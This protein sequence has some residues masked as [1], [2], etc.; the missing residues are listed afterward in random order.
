MT[1]REE[2]EKRRSGLSAAKQVLLEKRKQRLASMAEQ[3]DRIPRRPPHA[4]VPASFAQQ[5]FWFIHQLKPDNTAYNEIKTFHVDQPLDERVVRRA[6]LELMQRHE[7]LRST[8]A[9]ADGQLQQ[10][11]HPYEEAI[12][13]LS[14]Q[15][16]DIGQTP[17]E[18]REQEA[19]RQLHSAVRRP[20]DLAKDF[21]W[22]NLVI[23]MGEETIVVSVVHH[24]LCDGWGLDIFQRELETLYLAFLS[25]QPSPLPEL[26]VQYADF[27]FW[28][29]Q[30]AR[31]D[32]WDQQLAY[33][34]NTLAQASQQPLLYGDHPRQLMQDAPRASVSLTVPA[35]VT[36]KLRELSY[37]EGVTLFMVLLATFQ[38]LLFQYS[39]QDDIVVGTPVTRRSRPELEPLIGCFLNMLILRTDVAGDPTFQA[40]LQR[41]RATALG[42]YTNQDIPFETLVADLAPERHRNR[43]PFFQVMLDFQNYQQ[44][45]AEPGEA[46]HSARD[47]AAD[48]TQF[49]LVL[50]L[51]DAGAT[52]P[53]EIFYPGD[54]F[55]PETVEK[56][57]DRLLL[58]LETVTTD[59]GQPISAI[60]A[61][62]E[63]E[64]SLIARW[65]QARRQSEA[66]HTAS[67]QRGEER[68][69]EED[70][71]EPRTPLEEL[72]AGIWRQVLEIEWVGIHDNFFRIGGHS[73]LATQLLAQLQEVLDIEL[74][75]QIIFD[76]PTIA[77]LVEAIMQDEQNR[78][79]I[80]QS[81]ELLLSVTEM[82]EETVEALLQDTSLR[83]QA[84]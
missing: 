68:I 21:R 43:N 19:Q 67:E 1:T 55:T 75:L 46:S 52:L 39:G 25:E 10:V 64:R 83:V 53:G 51:W 4:P 59:L 80:E 38:L 26:E 66:E 63:S 13:S 74:P 36:R 57:R 78:A 14:L 50:R 24:I 7:I 9:F 42:A 60:A 61:L 71:G 41:V 35:S 40:L 30:R 79:R 27:A 76:A 49:D 12:A 54:L 45:G 72:L 82:S 73:L 47:I 6:L 81:I 16:C 15:I 20:F 2:L 56:I 28:E 23:A 62:D 33:W 3:A 32:V 65:E 48:V 8:F 70:E 22:R 18:L 29:Q 69:G 84:G 5:R 77:G 31:G 58:L 17:L 37:R 11:V 44:L 34:K